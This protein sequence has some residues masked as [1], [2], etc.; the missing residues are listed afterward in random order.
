MKCPK[1]QNEIQNN[2]AKFCTKCGCNIAEA[3]ANANLAS[4]IQ[5]ASK[6][7]CTK[8]GTK[9]KD[10]AKFCAKCGAPTAPAAV[11]PQTVVTPVQEEVKAVKQQEKV[12][13]AEN[14][15]IQKENVSYMPS[16]SNAAS[17]E[18]QTPQQENVSAMPN[19]SNAA[20]TEN[21]IPQQENVS[22]M[23]NMSNAASA[24]STENQ[25]PQ[26][27]NMPNQVNQYGNMPYAP[28]PVVAQAAN[29]APQEKSNKKKS[30]TGL[31][32]AIA[33]LFVMIIAAGTVGF[34]VWKGNISVPSLSA[35]T[36]KEEETSTEEGTE[37]TSVEETVQST[38]D[39]E[40]LFAEADTMINTG[41]DQ[42][43]VDAE[44]V[45]GMNSLEDAMNLLVAKAEEAGDTSLAA[46]RITDTYASYVT[47]V[48]KHKDMLNGSTLSGGIYG[49]VM[50]EMNE[51]V[52]LGEELTAKGYTID[53]SSLISARDEFDKTYTEKIITTF[54]E[55]T[56]RETWSR[57]ESWNLMSETADYM[58]DTSDLD[59]PIRLRY[60]YALSWWIQK[61]I[62]TE[63]NNGTITTK[64]AA[65]KIANLIKDMD[66][67]PMMIHYYITYMQAAG[68][69]CS[70]V[71]V[72][73]N[74]IVAHLE[75]TQGLRIGVDVA[76]DH[77]WYFNDFGTYS[78][79]DKN[80]VTKENRQWIR[81]L[82]SDVTFITQ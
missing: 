5:S 65:I 31:V 8:C 63:I 21:Q 66:Y 78:V 60:A 56:T 76:L 35:F 46:E 39:T 14:Q 55:F 75:E 59:N 57:T 37:S 23:P 26:H 52:A 15:T 80:G 28:N 22:Y 1:C 58:F 61:Q 29:S 62:E 49:Q 9:L 6:L 51:A 27:V 54:D 3:M 12:V 64:G 47:A 41:K 67:N 82:M 34:L 77:F 70:E 44:I 18:N 2:N 36:S 10:G 38:I 72:A 50:M 69:D 53:T 73:Y 43:T 33:L 48:I 68:E 13:T 19:M 40:E 24:V 81:D 25:T 17:T 79:D 32:I 16:M 20:S 71:A 30:S 42:I 7:F 45:N 11:A 4:E 74:N